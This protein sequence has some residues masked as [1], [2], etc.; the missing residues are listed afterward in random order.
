MLVWLFRNQVPYDVNDL[1]QLLGNGDGTFQTPRL[2]FPNLDPFAVVEVNGDSLPDIIAMKLGSFSSPPPE[3]SVYLG[4]PDG[5]FLLTNT[6]TPYAGSTLFPWKFNLGIGD[7]NG[8][9]HIDLAAFQLAPGLPSR[10]YVQFLTGNGDGTFTPTYNVYEFHKRFVPQ[11][12]A[13]VTGDGRADLVELDGYSAS[14]HVLPATPAQALQ[15]HLLSHPIIGATGRARVSLNVPSPSTTTVFL[16]ASDPAISPPASVDIPA[17]SLTAEFQ[18]TIA[19]GFD[20]HRVF[21]L[22]AQL[23]TDTAIAYGTQADGSTTLGVLVALGSSLQTVARGDTSRE[24]VV[25]VLSIGGYSSTVELSCLS[26]P[27]DMACSFG[28]ASLEIPAGGFAG[29]S[30]LVSTGPATPPGL[31]TI[32]VVASDG[33]VSNADTTTLNVVLPPTLDS[34][35]PASATAG[36]PTFILTLHGS[37]FM[38]SSRVRWNGSPRTTTFVSSNQLTATIPSSD[39]ATPGS[40]EVTVFN[41]P[42]GAG[43][44][45]PLTFTINPPIT[46]AFKGT[47]KDKAGI[48]IAGATLNAYQ[49]GVLKFSTSTA[50]NGTYTL[51]VAAGTYDLVASQIG[52]FD[53]TK[54]GLAIAENQTLT[55]TNFTLARHSFF[56]GT[57]TDS[58]TGEPLVGVLVEAIKNRVV[59]FSTTTAADGTYSLL[60][61]KG[62]YNL[63]ASKEGYQS[64][65]KLDRIIGDGKTKT[66]INFRLSP[67]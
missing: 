18:F 25:N 26:L 41:G 29:T 23:G 56:Q 33:I 66:G 67:Q 59:Q 2:L 43:T 57:V 60:V 4:Q 61:K 42:P 31:H 19:P 44:S 9:S 20:P 37:N 50:G 8:D 24:I 51:A 45:N 35:S 5:T 13:D 36:G 22:Q 11:F 6:Y 46:S 64:K 12:V 15:V 65:T 55:G 54:A 32:T 3:I 14:F 10:A 58:V 16:S 52:F 40:A 48:G 53:K 17:G 21:F 1:Y 47:V 28:S 63:R 39:I 49:G 7:F 27:A 34:L 38:L 30:L 62:T